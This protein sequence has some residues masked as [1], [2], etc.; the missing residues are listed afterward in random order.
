[1]KIRITAAAAALGLVFAGAALAP[2][3]PAPTGT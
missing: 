2:G 3:A 1:M